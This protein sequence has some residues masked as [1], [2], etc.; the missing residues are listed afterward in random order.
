[1]EEMV[2]S[3]SASRARTVSAAPGSR[4]PLMRSSSA[5]TLSIRPDPP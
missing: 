1:M 3:T 4:L 5:R 2:P